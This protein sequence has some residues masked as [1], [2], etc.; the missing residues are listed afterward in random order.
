MLG[1][2]S[3]PRPFAQGFLE[4]NRQHAKAAPHMPEH[5][6]AVLFGELSS[7]PLTHPAGTA[8]L[9][10][11]GRSMSTVCP[12]MIE[13]AR[14]AVATSGAIG[15]RVSSDQLRGT[16]PVSSIVPSA[17]LKPTTPH[18]DA[19]MRIEPPVSLPIAQSH[20]WA[21]TATAEPPDEPPATRPGS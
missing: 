5:V 11:A 3:Q 13:K 20:I 19:G 6:R 2:L 17:G 8:S 14:A 10:L 4:V 15:P 12:D 1:R 16:T 21:A 7:N 9:G 18:S